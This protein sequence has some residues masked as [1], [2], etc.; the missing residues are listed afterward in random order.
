KGLTQTNMS[1]G[2]VGFMAPEQVYDAKY[3]TKEADIFGLGVTLYSLLAGRAPFNGTSDFQIF[4]N[5]IYRP[6]RPIADWR[7][8][9]SE[10]TAAVIDRCLEKKP[11]NRYP[12]GNELLEAL[13]KARQACVE[14]QQPASIAS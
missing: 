10:E 8:D 3:V 4:T 5:T 14:R 1:L 7:P 2:T 11:D 13:L 9:V 6:H 12:D